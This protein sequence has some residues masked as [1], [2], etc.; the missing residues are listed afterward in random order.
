MILNFIKELVEKDCDSTQN[1]F[2]AAFFSQHILVVRDYALRL[3]GQLNA[4]PEAVELAAYLHDISAI[5]DFGTLLSHA[6]DG[7]DLAEAILKDKLPDRS[8]IETIRRAVINHS[9]PVQQGQ[10]S[11]EEVSLSNA[12]AISQIIRPAYWMYY[13][14]SVRKMSFGQGMDWYR[15]KV[16]SNWNNLI[17]QAKDLIYDE[18]SLTKTAFDLK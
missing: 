2:G 8:K 6:A 17:P 3:A 10:G 12:D 14:F 5:R 11:P 1:A 15:E 4:D 7:A 18:Y 13:V 16:N 9:R